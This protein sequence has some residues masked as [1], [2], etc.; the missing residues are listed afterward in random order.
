MIQW[1]GIPKPTIYNV[2]GRLGNWENRENREIT[3]L[4]MGVNKISSEVEDFITDPALK[5]QD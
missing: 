1:T 2:Y 3:V 4:A 5:V